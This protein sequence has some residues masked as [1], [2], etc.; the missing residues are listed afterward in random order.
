[1]E[2]M[3]T[4]Y[5]IE[6]R[7]RGDDTDPFLEANR[8]EAARLE[9]AAMRFH[10]TLHLPATQNP[11]HQQSTPNP[12]PT[13][14]QQSSQPT[15]GGFLTPAP[16]S[17]SGGLFSTPSGSAPSSTLFGPSTGFTPQSTPFGSTSGSLFGS[18]TT[19]AFG[20]TTQGLASTPAIGGGSSLFS[21]PSF[22]T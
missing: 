10:P 22:G 13:L 16:A 5:F 9:A 4:A 18:T 19:T 14:Q 1:M 2:S 8:R 21:T 11:P 7:R 15:L 12:T 6:Q 17:S 20:S 3:K